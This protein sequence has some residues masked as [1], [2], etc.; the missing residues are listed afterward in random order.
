MDEILKLAQAAANEGDV[1]AS[2]AKEKKAREKKVKK[3]RKE[4]KKAAKREK[5]KERKHKSSKKSKKRRRDSSSSSSSSSSSDDSDSDSADRRGKKR[6][7]TEKSTKFT[8]SPTRPSASSALIGPPRPSA[9]QAKQAKQATAPLP[10]IPPRGAVGPREKAQILAAAQAARVAA[11]PSNALY[12]KCATCGI[13]ASGETSFIEH[14]NG[15]KHRQRAGTAGFAGLIPNRGGVVPPLTDPQLRAAAL[16]FNPKFFVDGTDARGRPLPPNPSALH[17]AKS[18]AGAVQLQAPKGPWAPPIRRV[19]VDARALAAVRAQLGGAGFNGAGDDSKLADSGG[20]GSDSDGDSD[21]DEEDEAKAK[22]EAVAAAARE[23]E[24]GQEALRR[25]QTLPRPVVPEGGPM[26]SQREGLPVFAHRA[27][28]LEA[29]NGHRRRRRSSSSGGGSSGG[30]SSSRPLSG[31]CV[32][33]GETGSGKTTQVAQFLLEDAAA[34]GAPVSIVCTQPRRISAISVAERVA[35]ER[36]E[37][38]GGTVGYAIRGE[39]CAGSSTR[40]LFCTTGILLRRLESD[41]TLAG[42]THVLVDEVHE[43][44]LE[45]DFLLMALKKL[46]ARQQQQQQLHAGNAGNAGN[47]APAPTLSVGLMSAT[48]PGDTMVRY[49]ESGGG[50]ATATACP[51]VSFPGRAFP[52]AELYLEAALALV[53]PRRYR[54]DPSSDWS[55][56]SQAAQRRARQKQAQ[57]NAHGSSSSSGGG[58][59]GGC[60][61]SRINQMFGESSRDVARRFPRLPATVHEAMAQLDEDAVNVALIVELCCWYKSQGGVAA[62][63]RACRRAGLGGSGSAAEEEEEEEEDAGAPVG[64]NGNG[65]GNGALAVLVFLPGTREIADVQE[66]LQRSRDFGALDDATQ[67]RGFSQPIGQLTD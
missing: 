36:G 62:A 41:P 30:G 7:R 49:F 23:R 28:L 2:K 64:S 1:R 5:K 26:R 19:E 40:L 27:A 24:M 56:S 33:E 51:R 43:R 54:V 22:A 12:F 60:S 61:D 63:R 20:S 38:V 14:I 21:D 48:M 44:S 15:G 37:K 46:L 67:V 47:A 45:S 18:N 66:A 11:N 25:R 8:G 10:Y 6:P 9:K 13:E 29:L 31:A 59:G 32:I 35:A 58:G 65:N 39:N 3:R 55:R 57:V 17:R 50:T 53:G 34:T 52:V 42:T 16:R 4:E